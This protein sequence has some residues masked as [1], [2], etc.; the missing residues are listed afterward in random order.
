MDE[1]KAVLITGTSS[2][3]GKACALH[4]DKLG[5]KV[6]A[7]VRREEDADKL[8]S[9]GSEKLIPLI[10]DVTDEESIVSAVDKI[11]QE[12][13][14]KLFGLVNNAGIG[15]SGVV[16]VTPMEE[17]RKLMEV[18]VIGLYAVTK[19]CIPLIRKAKG[20]IINI[21]STSSFLAFPGSSVY[22]A[23]KFAVRAFT[24]S[25]RVEMKL[26]DV[27]V[28]LVAP[29]AV[30]SDI[31]DKGALFKKKLRESIDPEVAQ[32]YDPFIKFGDKMLDEIKPIPAIHVADAVTDAL[33]SKKPKLCYLVGKDARH[34]YRATKLPRRMVEWLILKQIEKYSK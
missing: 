14:G 3:I 9:E 20:R 11:R 19:S 31:W 16:E 1:N 21:G 32:L 17:M 24:D 12:N 30:E 6:Y 4:L 7:G 27:P 15:I 28:I 23:S 22:C 26:F 18:N 34:A 33:D 29:G 25:L 13:D 10:L 2:G 8:K 5:Y